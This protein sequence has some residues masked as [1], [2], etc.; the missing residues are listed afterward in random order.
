MKKRLFLPNNLRSLSLYLVAFML[1]VAI[2][3]CDKEPLP[4]PS[5]PDPD[6]DPDPTEV[7]EQGGSLGNFSE[8]GRDEFNPS[9]DWSTVGGAPEDGYYK[10]LFMDGGVRLT[11]R[12]TLP[13]SAALG[14]TMEYFAS[15][16]TNDLNLQD[17]LTQTSLFIGN[18]N[19]SNGVLLYPDGAPRFKMIYINGGTSWLHGASLTEQGLQNVRNFVAM[20]G[21]Y[22][23]SCAGMFMACNSSYSYGNKLRPEFFRVWP[24]YARHT[25]LSDSYTGHFVEPGSP[26][27]RYFDFGGDMHIAEVRHNGGGFLYEP[28]GV[29]AGTETLLRYDYTP[30]TSSGLNIH[31]KISAWAYK[32]S[33]K[34]GRVVVIGSHPE[35]VV[36]GERLELMQA[37]VLYA[38]DGAGE[39]QLKATLQK[40][41]ARTMD[42]STEDRNPNFTK[43][44]DR[45]YH[46]FKV[47]IPNGAKNVKATLV[48]KS[49]YDLDLF[50]KRGNFAFSKDAEYANRE[51]Q[52]AKSIEIEQINGSGDWYISVFCATTVDHQ[53]TEWGANYV[54]NVS[55]LNGVPYTIS[56]TWQ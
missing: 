37:M 27:L 8:L 52:V 5:E 24:G 39:P 50:M 14:I 6:P 15:N 48:G 22:V 10:D 29:P 28:W 23:G 51:K 4:P 49:G 16:G 44:G 20:G 18:E 31:N 32:S 56:I 33:A 2:A 25:G 1:T 21:S 36:E 26:L 7:I 34:T 47:N 40:G 45:Q 3:A 17:T 9:F 19:D 46:H 42:K 54:G 13:A 43:I 41:A 38:L 53:Y 11:S 35:S 55:V 30:I 12:R